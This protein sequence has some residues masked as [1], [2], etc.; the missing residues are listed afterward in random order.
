AGSVS[1]GPARQRSPPAESL[2][3]ALQMPQPQ[4]A[5]A[6]ELIGKVKTK[7]GDQWE[8]QLTAKVREGT[9][10]EKLR[11]LSILTQFGPKPSHALLVDA[12]RDD[13]GLVRAFA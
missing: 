1:D 9:T 12:T 7:L 2:D 11:A 3:D 6:R 5:W 4:S 13:S 8:P 10:H